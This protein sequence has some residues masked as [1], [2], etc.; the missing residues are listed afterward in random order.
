MRRFP[1][2][3]RCFGLFVASA[4]IGT[5]SLGS[6]GDEPDVPLASKT[7]PGERTSTATVKADAGDDSLGIAGKMMTLNGLRSEPRGKV[8]YRWI[9]LNG[10]NVALKLETGSMLAFVP[11][12][13]GIYRFA[14]VVAADSEISEPDDVTVCVV[15]P[16]DKLAALFQTAPRSAEAPQTIEEQAKN[17]IRTVPNGPG[18]SANLAETF[19]E[20]SRRVELYETFGDAYA[21]VSRRLDR[22]VPGD[23]ASRNAWTERLF[24]PLSAKLAE[25][26]SSEGLNLRV[27][28]GQAAALTPAQKVRLSASYR[29]IARGFRAA[30]LEGSSK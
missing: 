7:K 18:L 27:E 2:P 12:S 4:A 10:P 9:Q 20:V 22:I 15:A 21:E 3:G 28:S 17:A 16:D 6:L 30:G 19:E 1:R 23:D 25:I 24:N 26:M 5:F 13:P 11:P 8:G 14:L 29:A